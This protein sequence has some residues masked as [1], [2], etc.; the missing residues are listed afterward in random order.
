MT[1][2]NS[3]DVAAAASQQ[4]IIQCTIRLPFKCVFNTEKHLRFATSEQGHTNILLEDHCD[5]ISFTHQQ[6]HFSLNLEKFK[7]T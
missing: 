3:H 2:V 4:S 6:I 1:A 7:F 5:Y